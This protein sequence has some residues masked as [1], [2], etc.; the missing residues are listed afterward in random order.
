MAGLRLLKAFFEQSDDIS[1]PE[2]FIPEC[3]STLRAL[4]E[5]YYT[6]NSEAN[7]FSAFFNVLRRGLK[8][9][10]ALLEALADLPL[11]ILGHLHEHHNIDILRCSIS[12][13]G[14]CAK[15]TPEII[16]DALPDYLSGLVN[17]L[18]HARH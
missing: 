10:S 13:L 6:Q 9:E 1:L 3:A 16:A 14:A 8:V 5:S 2:D 12:Y 11:A 15:Y 17:L 4:F 18:A 7:E